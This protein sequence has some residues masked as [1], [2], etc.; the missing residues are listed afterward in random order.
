MPDQT[1]TTWRTSARRGTLS[2][3]LWAFGLATT[4]L[5]VGLWGRAV[6]HDQPTIQASARSAVSADVASDRIYGWIEDAVVSSGDIDPRAAEQAIAGLENRPEVEEAIGALV[7]QFVNA[8]FVDEGEETNVELTDTLAPIVPLVVSALAEHDQ[9]IDEA[10]VAAV[11]EQ[12]EA[13]DLDSGDA[14]MIASAADDAR[15]LLSVIVVLAA[16]ALVSTGSSAVWLSTDRAAMVRLLATRVVL[17]ALSF[18]VL[19]RV[20]AWVL[21]PDRGGSPIASGSSILLGSN[22]HVFLLVAAAGGVVA[23]GIGWYVWRVKRTRPGPSD[24][25]EVDSDTRELVNV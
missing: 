18:A 6:T 17:S 7:D 21:D 12:A 22:A 25:S 11:I 23:S 19:F 3:V 20:G 4:L 2:V 5:L 9:A 16:L 1:P 13:I 8:L 14:A 10:T 24:V 15:S